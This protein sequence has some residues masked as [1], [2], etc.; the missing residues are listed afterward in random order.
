MVALHNNRPYL[1]RALHALQQMSVSV[2]Q[3]QCAGLC[4]TL[5]NCGL[6]H[7]P[8]HWCTKLWWYLHIDYVY[9]AGTHGREKQEEQE[10]LL[11]YLWA[12]RQA[13]HE[14]TQRSYAFAILSI[15]HVRVGHNPTLAVTKSVDKALNCVENTR[16]TIGPHSCLQQEEKGPGNTRE[17]WVSTRQV[18]T[19]VTLPPASDSSLKGDIVPLLQAVLGQWQGI[20]S[21]WMDDDTCNTLRALLG[22]AGGYNGE[23]KQTGEGNN[24]ILHSAVHKALGRWTTQISPYLPQ[25]HPIPAH[26]TLA[27]LEGRKTNI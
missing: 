27:R 18:A 7:L 14:P 10:N 3:G 11:E 15:P 23:G 5:G 9:D 8:L 24:K 20:M 17:E 21:N 13:P 19:S 16:S 26:L 6:A 22:L 25:L 2:S 4:K 1:S 12:G